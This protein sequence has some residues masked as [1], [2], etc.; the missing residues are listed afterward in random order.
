MSEKSK[1]VE[2]TPIPM[3]EDVEALEGHDMKRHCKRRCQHKRRFNHHHASIF[4]FHTISLTLF[5]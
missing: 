2:Y 5:Y 4:M 3:Q 1:D